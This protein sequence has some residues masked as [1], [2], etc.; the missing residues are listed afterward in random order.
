MLGEYF[1]AYKKAELRMYEFSILVLIYEKNHEFLQEIFNNNFIDFNGAM[2]YLETKG[3]VKW[4]GDSPIDVTLRKSGESLFNYMEHGKAKKTNEKEV[5]AWF[6]LWR[7]IFPEGSNS[8]GYRYRGNRLEGLKKM[9]KFVNV[10]PE[11][12]KEEIFQATKNYV[13]RFA[14]RG[15]NYMQQAHYFIEKKDSGSTLASECESL[16]ERGKEQINKEPKHGER[17]I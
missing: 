11:F 5:A 8:A 15:Y 13:E 16:R 6:N 2:H 7:E 17:L 1:E 10:Y 12:T 14:I 9:I 3:Y 4:Y